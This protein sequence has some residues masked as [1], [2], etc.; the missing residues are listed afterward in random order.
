MFRRLKKQF[1]GEIFNMYLG[2]VGSGK[3]LTLT[4]DVVLPLLKKNES[5]ACSY[6]VNWNKSN[7]KYFKEFD[8]IKGIKNSTVVFDE[9]GYTLDPRNWDAEGSGVRD[10]F[11]LHRH[12]F[13]DIHANTQHFSLIAKTARIQVS[14][15][16]LCEQ[17]LRLFNLPWVIIKL[18]ELTINQVQLLDMPII[19]K[20]EEQE[21][22]LFKPVSTEY[23]FFNKKK[24]YHF[25]LDE[26]KQELVHRYCPLCRHRQGE[27][28]LKEFTP[29]FAVWDNK[30]KNYVPVK[31]NLDLGYCPKHNI[32]LEL[33]A[34]PFY[35]SHYIPIR[36][37][38]G[39][40]WKP[41]QKVSV[42]KILPFKGNL[43][44]EQIS[45]LNKINSLE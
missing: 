36:T 19:H 2:F 18:S 21:E 1:T 12:A 32:P 3:S 38:K 42:D 25:E 13:V 35:D 20:D 30:I 15:F 24:L 11:M 44:D 14:R 33:R 43:S 40:L 27:P 9:V 34:T 26:Y 31:D 7:F 10:F 4:E 5:V 29:D 23:R 22:A 41:Y 6:W 39:I 16:Y 17:I 37:N 28:I 45:L 8:E